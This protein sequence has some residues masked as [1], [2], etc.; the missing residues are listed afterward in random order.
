M[1]SRY[2]IELPKEYHKLWEFIRENY[3]KAIIRIM[4]E[5]DKKELKSSE[6]GRS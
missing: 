3:G 6:N 4:I 5:F 1:G 2:Y